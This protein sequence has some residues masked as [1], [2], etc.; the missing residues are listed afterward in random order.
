MRDYRFFSAARFFDREKTTNFVSRGTLTGFWGTAIVSRGTS[1]E[2]AGV[3]RLALFHVEQWALPTQ[4]CE[5][6]VGGLHNQRA[7]DKQE[8]LAHKAAAILECE[9]CA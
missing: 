8:Y 9:A 2:K 3:S 7:D 6:I 4:L 1:K 5:R